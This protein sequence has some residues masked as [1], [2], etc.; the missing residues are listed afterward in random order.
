MLADRLAVL[1]STWFESEEK[2]RMAVPIY[3]IEIGI[4]ME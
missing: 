4:R 1:G 2:N 3:P